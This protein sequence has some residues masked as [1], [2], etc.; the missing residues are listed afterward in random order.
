MSLINL[1]VS[2]T[3]IQKFTWATRPTSAQVG[4]KI[5]ITDIG[6]A[7]ETFQFDGT[8]WFPINGQINL[9][10]L[11][12]NTSVTGTITNTQL[13]E[14]IVPAGLM[15]VNGQL[16]IITLF[17]YTNS[18]GIKTLRM[19]FGGFGGVSFIARN[20]TTTAVHQFITV[21]RNTNSL[22]S[23][24]A[25]AA[26]TVGGVGAS[27]NSRVITTVDTSLAS[28]ITWAGQLANT[29]DVITLKSYKITYRE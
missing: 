21:I 12:I 13:H 14:V 4:T 20:E 18:A 1:P 26:G 23:Q 8:R 11:S 5:I 25:M 15:S 2:K 17:N 24:V 22:S 7:D 10:T 19:Y 29:A 16:E 9:S 6:P 28:S 3:A 27:T